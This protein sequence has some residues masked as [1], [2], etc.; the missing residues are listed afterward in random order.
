[1]SGTGTVVGN[2][3]GTAYCFRLESLLIGRGSLHCQCDSSPHQ[4]SS[5][6]VLLACTSGSVHTS[7]AVV[8]LWVF[9]AQ[10]ISHPR[11]WRASPAQ[12]FWVLT[13]IPSPGFL[14]SDG[15]P[16]PR[17]S[18]FRFYMGRAVK[19]TL[20]R[21]LNLSYKYYNNNNLYSTIPCKN[22][23]V[24]LCMCVLMWHEYTPVYNLCDFIFVL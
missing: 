22:V 12:V 21:L 10:T 23:R 20:T 9:S 11:F 4:R 15:H 8:F 14:G 16:Q 24:C 2:H 7:A 6:V 19:R 5:L 1:M 13:G 17:F 18:G 3:M